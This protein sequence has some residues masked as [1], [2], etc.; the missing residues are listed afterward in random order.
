MIIGIDKGHAIKGVR[1]ASAILDEVNEN[2]KVGN[3]L[4]EMLKEKGHTVIDCSCDVA[5]SVNEQLAGIVAKANKQHLDLFVSIHLNSG[6]GH[7]TETFT[8]PNPKESTRAKA[9]A[10]NDAVVSSCGFTNRGLKTANF[11]VLR[12]TVA[13]AILVE[14]CFTDSQEDA[15]KLNTE[16]VARAMF[17]GIT[18]TE[19]VPS[20]ASKP[21]A[22]A[23]YG[24]VTASVL[25]VRKGAGTQYPI[26]G[27]L[28]K[29]D[30]VKLDVKVGQWWSTY[31]GEHG[32]FVH[33]DYISVI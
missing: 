30:K 11:Y 32:G 9:K 5:Y 2:R 14:V 31:Y 27:Q 33:G 22:P 13:P 29:G 25:N 6:G 1:G 3:R 8:Y 12:K 23:G 24:V 10:I 18:G 7:G 26:V 15:N 28:K 4:I 20:E 21:S 16:A 19:Y 17:R